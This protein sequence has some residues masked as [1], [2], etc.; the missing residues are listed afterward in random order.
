MARVIYLCPEC[1]GN[2]IQA[3]FWIDLN[4]TRDAKNGQRATICDSSDDEYWCEDCESHTKRLCVVDSRTR[5]CSDCK[6]VH[7]KPEEKTE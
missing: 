3:P 7:K 4:S 5:Y 1:G 6:K 2:K